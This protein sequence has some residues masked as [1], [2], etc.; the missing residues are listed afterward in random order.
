[1]NSMAKIPF[2]IFD[3]AHIARAHLNYTKGILIKF[4]SE[5]KSLRIPYQV[6]LARFTRIKNLLGQGV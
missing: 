3:Y 6:R 5:Q 4:L 2:S 1:M